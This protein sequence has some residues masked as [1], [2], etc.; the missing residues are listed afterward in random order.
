MS[1]YIA[2]NPI[3]FQSVDGGVFHHY[4]L[5]WID[6]VTL[7]LLT[8]YSD[9]SSFCMARWIFYLRNPFLYQDIIYHLIYSNNLFE[10]DRMIVFIYTIVMSASF[11]MYYFVNYDT[12]VLTI[13]YIFT[14]YLFFYLNW[15][16]FFY[17]Y[18]LVLV[19][20]IRYN[21]WNKA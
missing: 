18:L 7:F 12:G 6:L 5:F 2:R 10:D 4:F 3:L 8:I 17:S 20:A 21:L 14:V 15:I 16:S 1:K 13:N 9:I 11:L 19:S